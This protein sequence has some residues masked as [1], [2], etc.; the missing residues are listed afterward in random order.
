MLEGERSTESLDRR[1]L[2]ELVR[3]SVAE[4]NEQNPNALGF[5]IHGSRANG[6]IEGKK[7]PRKD[8]DLDVITIRKNRDANASE[9]LANILWRNI[10][11][12]YNIS[13]DTGPWGSL[14]LEEILQA[15]DS[16]ADKARI[17]DHWREHLGDAPVVIGANS[18]VE[19]AVKKALLDR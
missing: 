15:A 1:T 18:E 19:S 8:S 9:A 11:P 12:K 17:I 13:L 5:V 2:V 14:E 3:K 6:G 4:A 16:P 10:G 7:Q